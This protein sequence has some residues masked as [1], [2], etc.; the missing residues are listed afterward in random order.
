MSNEVNRAE[1]NDAVPSGEG[2]PICFEYVGNEPRQACCRQRLHAPCVARWIATG[3]NTCPMC[4]TP[5]GVAQGPVPQLNRVA[6]PVLAQPDGGNIE[7]R[8]RGLNLGQLQL[9]VPNQVLLLQARVAELEN[10]IRIERE[11]N[12]QLVAE[13]ARLHV[14]NRRLDN[15]ND[16]LEQM[17][18]RVPR[19]LELA[20]EIAALAPH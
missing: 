18:D 15:D 1:Q 10:V 13:N 14:E 6:G 19:I 20:R 8:P 3:H 17:N 7:D 5:Y 12:A 4:R 16:W 2:C 9:D 11:R